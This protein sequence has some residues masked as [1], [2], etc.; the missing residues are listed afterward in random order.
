MK[1]V[2]SSYQDP[3]LNLAL[4]EILFNFKDEEFALFYVNTPSVIIGKNQ[5]LQNEVNEDFCI[6]HKI[7]IFRRISGGGAVYHDLGNL[8]YS[9]ISN[10]SNKIYNLSADFLMP[11]I[12][13]LNKLG[14]QT[15][16]GKRKDLWLPD[17]NKISGTA[18]HITATRNLHHGTI[19]YKSDIT[20]L[21]NSL[22]S[23]NID[24]NLKGIA[25]VVSPVKNISTYLFENQLDI[26]SSEVFFQKLITYIKSYLK[27]SEEFFIDM[28]LHH[29]I[30]HL[31]DSKYRLDSWN[32]KK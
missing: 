32:K 6:E 16:I 1:L 7:P 5:V 14:I 25:S 21:T 18:A 10:K 17:G 26:L 2:L 29:E 12:Y 28:E 8:S 23:N 20:Q 4:E 9:F 27:I 3:A 13:G 31:A 11:I 22:D 24:V 19:L 30:T 15:V